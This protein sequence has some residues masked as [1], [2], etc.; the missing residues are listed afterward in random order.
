MDRVRSL[1][2]NRRRNRGNAVNDASQTGSWLAQSLDNEDQST[3]FENLRTIGTNNETVSDSETLNTFV[4][5]TDTIGDLERLGYVN[6]APAF[7]SVRKL[8][9]ISVLLTRGFFVFPSERSYQHFIKSKRKFNNV[10]LKTKIGIPLFHA[11]PSALIKTIFNSNKKDPIMKISKYDVLPVD[12]SI[13]DNVEVV[14]ETETY[15][16][17]RFEFCEILKANVNSLDGK[18]KHE[19][20]FFNGVTIPM[21][22]FKDKKDIDTIVDDLPLRWFGFSSFASPFGTNDIKLLILDDNTP[23]YLDN[24][25]LS[26]DDRNVRPLGHLPV[27]GK[28]SDDN[29]SV[30]PKRRTLR[31]ASFEIQEFK[32]NSSENDIPW[33]T[34]ALTCMCILLHEYESRK[35]RRHY[36]TNTTTTP[37]SNNANQ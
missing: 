13:P 27:W 20:K 18:I 26:N 30:L 9:F 24:V 32:V 31:L 8:P 5:D 21:Y 12:Q 25:N 28:Y 17:I 16:V 2:G 23:N 14:T 36:N 10:D 4:S 11:V 1:I 35:E 34:Q 15:R 29:M 22:N 3:V 6:R 7:N 19:L 37:D 33:N